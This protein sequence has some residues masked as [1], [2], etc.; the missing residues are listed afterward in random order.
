MV[1]DWVQGFE[2]SL[3]SQILLYMMVSMSIVASLACF[4]TFAGM[5]WTAGLPLFSVR[6]AAMISSF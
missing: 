3:V 4:I 2:H 6:I 5:L 1:S